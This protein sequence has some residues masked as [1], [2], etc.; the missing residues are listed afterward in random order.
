MLADAFEQVSERMASN[1]YGNA[2]TA[3]NEVVRSL[4]AESVREEYDPFANQPTRSDVL[5]L[6]DLLSG[7]LETVA[8][9]FG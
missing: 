8:A 6:V 9:R 7:R 4:V 5:A 1:Q 2:A 3:M